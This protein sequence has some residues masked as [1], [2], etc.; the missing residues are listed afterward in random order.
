MK[1]FAHLASASLVALAGALF[2]TPLHAQDAAQAP[3]SATDAAPDAG[4]PGDSV[5]DIGPIVVT[6]AASGKSAR[7]SSISVSQINQDAV[8]A[9]TPRSQAEVLRTIPGLNVQDTAGPGG[10]SNIGVRGIPVS[11]G[12]S[13]YV[14]LQEDGLPVTLFGDI[15]FGNNDYWVRFDNNVDRVEAVRGGSASTFSSQAPGAVINYVSKTG[16]HDG[17][18]IGVSQAINYRETRVDFDYGGH[19]S[20]SVRFHVGGYAIDGNGPT[21]LPYKAQSG[22]QI[23]GNITKELADGKGY[24][25]LNFKRLDDKEP[26]FTSMPSLVTVDGNKV[27]GFSTFDGVNARRYASSGLYN[28]TFRVLDADGQLRTVPMEGIHPVVTSVGGEFHYE[29]SR[30]FTVT[31]K[32]RWTAM[33]GTFANQWTGEATTGS[34]AGDGTLRYAT[35]PNQGEIYGGRFVS[36]GAQAYVTMRDVG[37]FVNDLTLNGKFELGNTAK[38]NAHAGWFHM[39]QT[40]DMDWRINNMTQT[41]DSSGNPVPLDLFDAAGN[42]L[43]AMGVNGLNTQWG[44]CCGGRSYAVTYTNDALYGQLEGQIGRLNLDASVRY[45]T[46]KAGGV[47][48]ANE[49]VA[50]VTLS[51]ALGSASVPAYNTSA[52]PANVLNYAKGYVSWSFGALYEVSPSTSVFVRVSRGGRF[53]ADR[54]LYNNANFTADGKLTA[55][56]SHL[57]LN[58]VTQQELGIKQRGG[59]LGGRY[60]AEVTLYRAQVKES[61]YDFT[62]PSRGE[63]PFI[64][65]IY[66]SYGV[67]ASGGVA[68]GR[69]SLDG[70][71]VYTHSRNAGTG[72]TPVAMPDWTWLASPSYDAGIAAFGLSASGQSNFQIAGGYRVRGSTFLNGYVKVRPLDGLEVSFNVNNLLNTLGYRANNGSLTV[73]PGSA[74]LAANQA[75]LDNS[76]MLGRTMT[77]SVR[78]R[79]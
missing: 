65:A 28:Q 64:D 17:G 52:T 29:F 41:L 79:F 40:I 15:M 10:N 31:D 26:T 62:A 43:G 7:L 59:L 36:N 45:D 76:A 8:I 72:A 18:Q 58:Y 39:R 77:A 47:A 20:D 27:T 55:G 9:F 61:N 5:A 53:N 19:L 4:A 74:G 37:S 69:F 38:I 35:G 68:A 30:A 48:Y 14:G 75:I 25:R 57:S 70:Y 23:K 54:L 60:H 46:V 34:V 32:A 12:G 1:P 51:D 6:A 11:T 50:N 49:Q 2:A 66:H 3:P 67:E 44:A 24:I 16:E 21:H 22:Y 71:V 56:G 73:A 78:Y 63:N 13:E 42:Q 33:R